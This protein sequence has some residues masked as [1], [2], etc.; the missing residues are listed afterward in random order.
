MKQRTENSAPLPKIIFL[1]LNMPV[2]DGWLFLEEFKKLPGSDFVT[3]YILTSSLSSEDYQKASSLGLAD[4][5]LNKPL[6]YEHLEEILLN[7]Q[8]LDEFM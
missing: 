3:V 7:E 8:G 2:W 5:Y 4:N 1:D 6:K